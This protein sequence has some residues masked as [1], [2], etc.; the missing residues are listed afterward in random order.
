VTNYKYYLSADKDFAENWG[1][2]MKKI[3]LISVLSLLLLSLMIAPV[4]AGPTDVVI[5][6]GDWFKYEAKVTQW[7]STDPFLPDGYYGPLSVADNQT[8]SILY[9]VTA[10]TPVN[11]P[12]ANSKKQTLTTHGSHTRTQ[13]P[14]PNLT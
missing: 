6:V 12:V 4:M 2:T 9:T 8:N 10:I 5:N 14:K 7:V 13:T 1:K 11:E 3:A